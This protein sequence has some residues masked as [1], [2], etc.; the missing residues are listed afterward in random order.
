L[1]SHK[2]WWIWRVK[3][4]IRSKNAMCNFIK[5]FL[6]MT[7]VFGVPVVRRETTNS[8]LGAAIREMHHAALN[9]MGKKPVNFPVIRARRV[10]SGLISF[11]IPFFPQKLT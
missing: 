8:A 3:Y 4:I 6:I 2:D 11:L 7:G 1:N 9:T 10:L 5:F